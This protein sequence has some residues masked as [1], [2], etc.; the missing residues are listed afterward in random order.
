MHVY[1]NVI[2]CWKCKHIRFTTFYS[3]GVHC[4]KLH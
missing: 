2:T 4:F 3:S 1:K